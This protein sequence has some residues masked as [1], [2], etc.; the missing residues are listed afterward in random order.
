MFDSISPTVLW[1]TTG[2]ALLLVMLLDVLAA[3]LERSG[4]IRLRHWAEEA[5]GGLKRAY[6]D[7]SRFRA[8][9]F[10]LRILSR[11]ALVA[12]VLSVIAL[13]EILGGERVLVWGTLSLVPVIVVSELLVQFLVATRSEGALS[14]LTPV[15]RGAR[16]LLWPVTAVVQTL[17]PRPESAE[18]ELEVA[19]EEEIDAFID[20][21]RREGI[22][23]AGEGELVRGVVDFGDTQV[24]SVMTPRVDVVAAPIDTTVE[25]FVQL[26]LES[27]HS[28]I[29]IYQDSIDHVV[30]VLH[31]R[32]LLR[33]VDAP[34]SRE[35]RSL[36]QPPHFVPETKSLASLLRELQER[37]QELAVVVDEY[38]GTEGLVTIED[39]LE[40][41]FGE[42]VDEHD[43][44]GPSEVR[45]P[46]GSWRVD[47][48]TDLEDL[49]GLLDRGLGDQDYETVGGL[50]FGRLGHV[51]KVGERVEAH[52]LLFTVEKADHRRARRVRVEEIAGP[53]EIVERG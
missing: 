8:F 22:L 37:H 6:G 31:V 24:R 17:M 46:D 23:E 40:E 45:L 19:S 38:G 39:L 5:G 13:L 10:T 49:A 16:W 50:I 47:G 34:G 1:I 33:V 15:F 28:R 11:I 51:P 44:E 4:P 26:I 32:D 43:P 20:V 42:I 48:R 2:L 12:L 18:L 7:R 9:A 27:G 25:E 35:I 41:I 52:G 21:G 36:F 29:P 3:L 30:G 53:R 14:L